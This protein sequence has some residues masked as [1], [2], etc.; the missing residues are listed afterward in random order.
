MAHS[1]S[2]PRFVTDK[3]ELAGLLNKIRSGYVPSGKEE[4]G[5][6]V[7]VNLEYPQHLHSAHSEFPFVAEK[8]SITREMLSPRTLEL[9]EQAGKSKVEES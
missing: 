8:H 4:V 5:Y 9:L 3:C 6:F 1:T 2:E 7:E